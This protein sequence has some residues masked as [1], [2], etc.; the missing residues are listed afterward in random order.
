MDILIKNRIDFLFSRGEVEWQGISIP[1]SKVKEN[2]LKYEAYNRTKMKANSYTKLTAAEIVVLDNQQHFTNIEK[3]GLQTFLE[4]FEDLFLG[5]VGNHQGTNI[6]FELKKDAKP[7]YAK[8]YNI[9]VALMD[10]TKQAIQEMIDNDFIMQMHD[11]TE[12]AAPTFCVPKKTKGVR[13]VSDF[14]ALN[15]TM[16]I[17]KELWSL[18]TI[19]LP[20]GK[21]Q[22]K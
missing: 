10:L 8:P 4:Q 6:E 11:D 14:R 12:W 9:P 15:R 19:I 7:F 16:K 1:L 2:D 21:Y 3:E 17:K 13:V 5:R 22:Y 18:L 20:F